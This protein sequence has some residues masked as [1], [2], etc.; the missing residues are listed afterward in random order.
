MELVRLVY[1]LMCRNDS[2]MYGC[3]VAFLM[4]I[5]IPFCRK[6]GWLCIFHE[7]FC[8]KDKFAYHIVDIL[9][10][11]LFFMVYLLWTV[12]I[13]AATSGLRKRLKPADIEELRGLEFHH[14]TQGV[15]E[16]VEQLGVSIQRLGRKAFPSI[17]GRDY[18]G[19]LKGRFYQALLVRWQ[20]KLGC[21]KLEEGFHDLF[22]RARMLEEQEKQFAASAL[23]RQGT[24]T[25]PRK[26]SANRNDKPK[27]PEKS[28][29]TS[30]SPN[31]SP[32]LPKVQC[33][34][35][36]KPGHVRND[37]PLKAEAPG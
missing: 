36:K 9:R 3:K 20:R 30:A 13:A 19:L 18:D 25:R 27:Q 2:C 11:L 21:P 28:P 1:G 26:I 31:P 4:Y 24:S 33:Y 22:T 5:L 35:C 34:K 14:R 37:C 7:E 32:Q 17:T 15:D 23:S 29:S 10:N 6:C 12:F 8:E 16:T